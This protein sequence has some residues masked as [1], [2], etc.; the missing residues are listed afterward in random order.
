ML[1][2]YENEAITAQR[3]GLS[4]DYVIPD[5]TILIENPIAVIAKSKHPEQA[6]AFVDYALSPV[7]QQRF[8]DWGYRPV[9]EAVLRRNASRFPT[10]S[11]LFTIRDLGGWGRVNDE[12]FDPD[13]GSVA[14][15]E[16][17]AGVSAAK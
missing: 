15:I 12:F 16:A 11:G 2:S 10:P 8:A 3:K 14:R 6:R 13:R 9:D 17:D 5:R 7:A 1:I 4:V